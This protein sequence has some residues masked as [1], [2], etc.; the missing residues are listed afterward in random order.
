MKRNNET[1]GRIN[2]P[3]RFKRTFGIDYDEFLTRARFLYGNGYTAIKEAGMRYWIQEDTFERTFRTA[4]VRPLLEEVK[5]LTPLAIRTREI[6]DAQWVAKH[7]I[8][9]HVPNRD[10]ILQGENRPYLTPELD[11]Q[12]SSAATVRRE[13]AS[14]E[15]KVSENLETIRQRREPFVGAVFYDGEIG[16]SITLKAT[17]W[18]DMPEAVVERKGGIKLVDVEHVETFLAGLEENYEKRENISLEFFPRASF[19][20]SFEA[21][22]YLQKLGKYTAEFT[23]YNLRAMNGGVAKEAEKLK[24]YISRQL[25]RDMTKLY[26]EMKATCQPVYEVITAGKEWFEQRELWQSFVLT[27]KPDGDHSRLPQSFTQ[28]HFPQRKVM[29]WYDTVKLTERVREYNDSRVQ[30]KAEVIINKL[31]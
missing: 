23:S 24:V 29:S 20:L 17:L 21:R 15:E 7:W 12:I 25:V 26:Q 9:R 30:V 18:K 4:W 31:V 3:E 2:T 8:A 6:A 14:L 13:I 10:F 5:A 19:T 28:Q 22:P 1:V 16:A 11:Q 27:V